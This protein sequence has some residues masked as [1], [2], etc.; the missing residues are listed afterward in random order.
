MP[1]TC[2]GTL[3]WFNPRKGYGFI[4]P[5]GGDGDVF[6]HISTLRAAGLSHTPEGARMT[7]EIDAAGGKLRA[8]R[9]LEVGLPRRHQSESGW[10]RATVKWFNRARGFGF[11]TRGEGA[12]DIFVH[13]EVLRRGGIAELATGQEVMVRF[14][15]GE[16]GLLTFGVRLLVPADPQET[17]T[18]HSARCLAAG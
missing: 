4:V 7:C 1:A 3:S 8:L 18:R 11:L 2:S 16:K 13:M 10:V 6:I 12:E 5:D 9:V 17:L 14:S 15:P